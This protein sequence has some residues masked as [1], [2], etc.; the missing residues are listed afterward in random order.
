[1]RARRSLLYIRIVESERGACEAGQARCG[2]PGVGKGQEPRAKVVEDEK[3]DVH[4]VVRRQHRLVRVTTGVPCDALIAQSVSKQVVLGSF[5]GIPHSVGT[6]GIWRSWVGTLR[7]DHLE[8]STRPYTRP[9]E[10]SSFAPQDEVD[11][12][13]VRV[14]RQS[15]YA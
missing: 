12:E 6:K 13:R 7:V 9:I 15:S 11:G 3:E 5:T 2:D 8:W 1:M 4:A 14:L 10:V